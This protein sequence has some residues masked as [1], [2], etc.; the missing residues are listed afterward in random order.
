MDR[1][2][3][4]NPDVLTAGRLIRKYGIES[5]VAFYHWMNGQTVAKLPNGEAGYYMWDWER[6]RCYQE[7]LQSCIQTSKN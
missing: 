5:F 1:T 7:D 4:C 2:I 3:Y 6:F